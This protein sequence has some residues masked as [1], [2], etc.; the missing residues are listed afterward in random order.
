MSAEN[1]LAAALLDAAQEAGQSFW[2]DLGPEG[3]QAISA[4]T[5][6]LANLHARELLGE[7]VAEDIE[8]AKATILNWSFVGA[9]KAQT[10]LIQAC[11]RFAMQGAKV[12]AT[13]A[14]GLL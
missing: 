3:R 10:A 6:D 5:V 4:A 13:V 7:D 12:L 14:I 9:S 1:E 2:D 8:W 11:Q